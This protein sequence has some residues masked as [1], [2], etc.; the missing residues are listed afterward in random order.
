MTTTQTAYP[1]AHAGRR[2]SY[3]RYGDLPFG[4]QAQGI[5]TGIDPGESIAWLLIRLDGARRSLHVRPNYEGLTYLDEVVPVPDLPL[6]PFTPVANDMNGFYEH[7]G[8]LVLAIG[9]DGEDLVVITDDKETAYA[10]AIGYGPTL[11]FD[12]DYFDR[13]DMTAQWVVFEWQPEDAESTWFMNPA[14]EGD[15]QAVH[16]FY[17][18]TA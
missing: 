3:T 7:A 13:E 15:D 4:P 14:A 17:L 2:V 18:P 16:V 8:V 11:G 10:A 9:E 5:I 12:P 6:G 1:K